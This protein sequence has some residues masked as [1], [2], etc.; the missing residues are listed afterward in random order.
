[1]TGPARIVSFPQEMC[2]GSEL[3]LSLYSD[4]SYNLTC[5]ATGNPIPDMVWFNVDREPVSNSSIQN[6]VK[7]HRYIYIV[8]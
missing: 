1:M 4:V 6:E 8:T 5:E 3:V 7:M 2:Y